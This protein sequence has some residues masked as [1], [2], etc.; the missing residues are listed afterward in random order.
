MSADPR[1]PRAGQW[2]LAMRRLR[3]RRAEVESDLL[4]LYHERVPTHGIRHARRRYLRDALSVWLRGP[5][6]TGGPREPRRRPFESV[7]RDIVFG[8]RLYRRQSGLVLAMVM[9]LGLAIGVCTAAF[10]GV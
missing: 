1:P 8:A 9:S 6:S 4:E 10:S 3:D 2:L 5:G 7:V